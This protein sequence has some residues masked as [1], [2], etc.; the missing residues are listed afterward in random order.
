MS[1]K[2]WNQCENVMHLNF[3]LLN[4]LL[5][6][7]FLA[8]RSGSIFANEVYPKTRLLLIE[9]FSN[10]QKIQLPL[11]RLLWGLFSISQTRNALGSV[12]AQ[13]CNPS[14]KTKEF[15]ATAGYT[16]RP[17]LK[18]K[19]KGGGENAR[20]DRTPTTSARKTE[21]GGQEWKA[22]LGCTASKVQASPRYVRSYLQK[23]TKRHSK[24]P[25]SE[26]FC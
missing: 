4:S 21:A 17:C 16:V 20:H 7:S 11:F 13:T 22:S 26:T 14:T 10:K 24:P 8:L 25:S 23:Q 18:T 2:V 3:C 19:G 15:Q 1:S 12:M 9:N 6:D 5:Q